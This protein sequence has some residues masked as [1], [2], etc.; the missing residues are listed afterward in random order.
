MKNAIEYY[1]NL[2]PET[3]RQVDKIFKFSI[4][5]IKFVIMPILK[6]KEEINEIYKLHNEI[7]RNGYYCHSIILNVNKEIT[8]IING[9]EYI[10]IRDL[11]INRKI[12]YQDIK[13]FSNTQI[14]YK[15]YPVLTRKKWHTLWSK[16]M[17]YLEYQISQFG[18]KYPIIRESSSYFIG[19]VENCISILANIET[20]KNVY[21]ISHDRI[22]VNYTLF[23]L[24]N[25]INFIIDKRVR[26]IG[27]TIKI[28]ILSET[29]LI[30]QI[31][32]NIKLY[33]L[34]EQEIIMLFLR[35]IYP[36][37]YLDICEQIIDMKK[38]EVEIYEV[39]NRISIYE[40]NIKI[41]YD[42]IR[43]ITKIPEIEWLKKM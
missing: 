3:I 35:I 6:T 38:K 22:N 13:A 36:S 17:D 34:N 40:S 24:Y 27:E 12:D 19:I 25:P 2:K 33:K 42:Y 28:N 31:E 37:V 16:K 32:K 39:I 1:Y 26:D 4:S 10:L 30:S 5:N 23:D 43:R 18:K 41:I 29:D 8:T 15:N 21:S 14:N 20:D 7:L 9:I 11:L